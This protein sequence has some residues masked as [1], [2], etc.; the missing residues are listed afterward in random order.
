M[1][2]PNPPPAPKVGD[3]A[4]LYYPSDRYPFIVTAVSP[5]GSK[6]TLE[7]LAPAASEPARYAGPFPVWDCDGDPATRNQGGEAASPRQVSKSIAWAWAWRGESMRLP[8]N[9]GQTPDTTAT[10]PTDAPIQRLHRA[11]L[12]GLDLGS[13]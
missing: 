2:S 4:T 7:E 11:R 1:S 5:N 13:R 8:M 10:G 6:L 12:A 9:P 3:L